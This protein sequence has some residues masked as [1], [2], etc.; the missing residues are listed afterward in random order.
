MYRRSLR[1]SSAAAAQTADHQQ[2]LLPLISL[3]H[4]HHT[5]PGMHTL[6]AVVRPQHHGPVLEQRQAGDRPDDEA[7]GAYKVLLRPRQLAAIAEDASENICIIVVVIRWLT[8][9][10]WLR[11]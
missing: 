10:K 7:G 8:S 1:V 5:A 2:G 11:P 9:G 6:P 3:L 4:I